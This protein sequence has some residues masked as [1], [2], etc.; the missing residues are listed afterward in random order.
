M[1]SVSPSEGEPLPEHRLGVFRGHHPFEGGAPGVARS[2]HVSQCRLGAS[3]RPSSHAFEVPSP[4]RRRAPGAWG[5]RAARG[6]SIGRGA[7]QR[8]ILGLG[9]GPLVGEVD[10]VHEAQREACAFFGVHVHPEDVHSGPVVGQRDVGGEVVGA[11]VVRRRVGDRSVG[12]SRVGV[13]V[14]YERDRDPMLR[15]LH[16]LAVG[17]LPGDRE[18]VGR[19]S[20]NFT[21]VVA[22]YDRA[23]R[24]PASTAEHVVLEGDPADLIGPHTDVPPVP[25][26][27]RV[28]QFVLLDG[29]NGGLR[30]DGTF[31]ANALAA[32]KVSFGA[33]QKPPP[34]L[35]YVMSMG[36][37]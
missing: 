8:R 13:G 6:E 19:T 23:G 22:L 11:V 1:R 5:S 21:G 36:V 3:A 29:G 30:A 14:G 35:S 25:V 4:A 20:A 33:D 27:P 28:A 12:D 17:L 31:G 16:V 24:L 2:S 7:A 34:T 15:F 18:A 37:L 9:G 26:L 32:V 10:P